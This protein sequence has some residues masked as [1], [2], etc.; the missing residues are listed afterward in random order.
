MQRFQQAGTGCLRGILNGSCC[1]NWLPTTC[2]RCAA[3][4]ATLSDGIY[5]CAANEEAVEGHVGNYLR[6]GLLTVSAGLPRLRKVPKDGLHLIPGGVSK[7]VALIKEQLRSLRCDERRLIFPV[8][9]ATTLAKPVYRKEIKCAL[10]GREDGL[11]DALPSQ[12]NHAL[13]A[14]I[15]RQSHGRL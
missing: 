3:G 12:T 13:N 10:G 14:L 5:T 6:W 7:V 4:A 1:H 2:E 11:R 15:V 8:E 9:C